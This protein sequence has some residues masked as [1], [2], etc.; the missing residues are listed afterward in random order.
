MTARQGLPIFLVPGLVAALTILSEPLSAEAQITTG[1]GLASQSQAAPRQS[2]NEPEKKEPEAKKE[3][4][5]TLVISESAACTSCAAKPEVCCEPKPCGECG[6]IAGAGV[7]YL[8]PSFEDNT[9]FVSATQAG[10][11]LQSSATHF[12]WKYNLAPKIWLGYALSSG[13]GLRAQLFYFDQNS[14]QSDVTNNGV[15]NVPLLIHEAPGLPDPRLHTVPNFDSVNIGDVLAFNSHLRICTLDFEAT[16]NLT[17]GGW[18]FLFTGGGRYLQSTQRYRGLLT[19]DATLTVETVDFGH[20]FYGGGPTGSAQGH[21]HLG[22][23]GLALFGSA[24]GSLLVGPGRQTFVSTQN[25]PGSAISDLFSG[26]KNDTLPV[27]E[28]ELGLE[29]AQPGFFVQAAAV[30]QTYFG[31]GSA[32][33]T[34][35][36]LSLF[37]IQLSVGWGY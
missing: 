9:A 28:L 14:K 20:N 3:P 24:R 1:N 30:E 21:W 8:K 35:G 15:N 16:K 25:L 34:D 2:K 13:L 36:N 27:G 10:P 17:L 18:S 23:S 5:E 37:G 19:N 26:T 12:D 33:K 4:V 22:G 31:L 29:Y 6:W 32:S 7:Y 11:D